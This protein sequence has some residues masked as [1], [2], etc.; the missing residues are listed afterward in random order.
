MKHLRL[1]ENKDGKDILL[2]AMIE[3][4]RV[5]SLIVDFINLEKLVTEGGIKNVV[6]FYFEKD[7]E[8]IGDRVLIVVFGDYE[9][10]TLDI[11]SIMINNE[12]EKEI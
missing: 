10:R 2:D 5:C 8:V 7:V 1:F 4:E 11:P 9:E 6:Y 12:E 3:Y